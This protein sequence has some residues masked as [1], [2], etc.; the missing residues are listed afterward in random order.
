MAA[1]QH[2]EH[3]GLSGEY[4]MLP[5]GQ[6]VPAAEAPKPEPAKPAQPAPKAKD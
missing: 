3:H 1:D 5:S 2:Y 4:V 6:M